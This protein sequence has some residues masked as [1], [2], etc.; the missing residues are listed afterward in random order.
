LADLI[1]DAKALREVSVGLTAALRAAHLDQAMLNPLESVIGSASVTAA[2]RKG[3]ALQQT[4]SSALTR[5]ADRLA[6]AP[7]DAAAKF[8]ETDGVL[9]NH[10]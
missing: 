5:N 2:L 6:S 7:G 4:I 8:T 9:A 3:I 1:V 10:G